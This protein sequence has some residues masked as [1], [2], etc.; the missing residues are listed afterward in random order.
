M[1]RTIQDDFKCGATLRL[2]D[3]DLERISAHNDERGVEIRIT[4]GGSG[5]INGAYECVE[6]GFNVPVGELENVKI[7]IR[8]ESVR[9]LIDT[10][11]E[12][13]S[14]QQK[15]EGL[16]HHKSMEI[17]E[18][19]LGPTDTLTVRRGDSATVRFDQDGRIFVG[20]AMGNLVLET[21][22]LR[23]PLHSRG[24]GLEL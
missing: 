3:F 14:E 4:D 12:Y 19:K 13:L 5:T 11:Q 6:C 2:S 21:M 1:K 24:E 9:Q 18:I 22:G 17:V 7:C 15:Q 20:S 8:R 10:L 16:L 23:R